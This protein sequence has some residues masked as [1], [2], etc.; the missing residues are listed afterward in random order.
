V[1]SQAPPERVFSGRT[2]GPIQEDAFRNNVWAPLLR[3]A[4]LRYRKPHTLRH[5][6]ASMLIAPQRTHVRSGPEQ[7]IPWASPS[8]SSAVAWLDAHPLSR[9]PMAR[10]SPRRYQDRM[11]WSMRA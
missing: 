4:S 7:L 5:T 1:A 9:S 6:Y 11:R 8:S 2:G 3:R 10:G